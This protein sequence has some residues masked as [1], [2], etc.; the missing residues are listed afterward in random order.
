M[1]INMNIAALL[2]PRLLKLHEDIIKELNIRGKK[3]S[4]LNIQ[5]EMEQ[6]ALW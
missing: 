3:M 4:Q 2:L 1:H 6:V 5:V